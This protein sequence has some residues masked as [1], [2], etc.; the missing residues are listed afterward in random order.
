MGQ[1]NIGKD[2]S[3]SIVGPTGALESMGLL[4]EFD[5]SP[6]TTTLKSLPINMAGVPQ[7]RTTYQ[8]WRGTFTYDRKDGNLDL[9]CNILE[10][11]F[12]AGNPDPHFQIAETIRN[13]DGSIDRFVYLDCS[14]A[15]EGG[16][17]WIQDQKVEQRLRFEA[18]QRVGG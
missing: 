3:L 9:L 4:R 6:E 8:G 13:P 5:R 15:L 16:G 14:L 7:L 12:Y 1:F 2:V 18:A 17:R 11:N 10:A